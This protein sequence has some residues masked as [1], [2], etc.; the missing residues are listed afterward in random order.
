M[1]ALCTTQSVLNL[2]HALIL[3]GLQ[4][5]TAVGCLVFLNR[6]QDA[7]LLCGIAIGPSGEIIQVRVSCNYFLRHGPL[8]S[9]LQLRCRDLNCCSCTVIENRLLHKDTWAL[10]N[11]LTSWT[12]TALS[13]CASTQQSPW[14]LPH[15]NYVRIFTFR[16]EMCYLRIQKFPRPWTVA[17]SVAW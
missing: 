11:W 12:L 6:L 2:L 14:S 8:T 15:F 17:W 4:Y 16:C 3:T 1:R 9:R 10:G 7:R 13:D 5:G